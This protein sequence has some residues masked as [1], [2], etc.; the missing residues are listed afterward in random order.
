[1]PEF[2]A[3]ITFANHS[4]VPIGTLPPGRYPV[5]AM[6]NGII[7]F[8]GQ[9]PDFPGGCQAIGV[10]NGF[11]AGPLVIT[12]TTRVGVVNGGSTDAGDPLRGI[13]VRMPLGVIGAEII[14]GDDE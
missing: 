13:E 11:A 1:M 8:T 5:S 6:G 10:T 2:S 9:G 12:E 7:V 3:T 4:V 14:R